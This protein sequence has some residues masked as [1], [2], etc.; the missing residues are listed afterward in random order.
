M[1]EK[2]KNDLIIFNNNKINN[3]EKEN[4]I[5][6]NSIM[7]Y[8]DYELNSLK[9]NEALLNDKRKYLEYYF[10]L[11]RTKHILI[12]AI[13]P[14]NDYNSTIIKIC[15]FLFSFSLFFSV[16]ALFFNDSTIHEIYEDEGQFKFIYQLPKIIYSTIISSVINTIIRFFSLSEKDIL[17]LKNDNNI[18]DFISKK[19]KLYKCLRIKF[20]W[21][22]KIGF[23]FLFLFWYYLSCFCAIYKNTQIHLLK[24]TLLSFLLSLLYPFGIYLIPGIFR[25][26]SLKNKKKSIYILS[27]IIQIL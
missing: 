3:D 23:L 5:K 14:S 19:K 18:K 20:I 2:F 15:L 12:F 7:K 21:F 6:T 26:Y 1:I 8:N 16:N 17:K 11:L 22:F 13:I 24:D 27:K 25:I 4:F 10:S 9:Y